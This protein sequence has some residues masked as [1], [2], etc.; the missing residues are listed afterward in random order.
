MHERFDQAEP[1]GPVLGHVRLGEPD[2]AWAKLFHR[3]RQHLAGIHDRFSRISR[4]SGARRYRARAG[5]HRSEFRPSGTTFQCRI[6]IVVPYSVVYRRWLINIPRR[7]ASIPRHPAPRDVDPATT[8]PSVT[9][10]QR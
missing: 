1:G 7:A 2:P 5:E 10:W 9:S 3:E 4:I 6:Q 8:W